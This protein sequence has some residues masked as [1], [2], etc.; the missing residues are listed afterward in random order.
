MRNLHFKQEMLATNHDQTNGKKDSACA[1]SPRLRNKTQAHPFLRDDKDQSPRSTY[2]RFENVMGFL[3]AFRRPGAT[4]VTVG[5]CPSFAMF[6]YSCL[7]SSKF[8]RTACFSASVFHAVLLCAAE[9]SRSIHATK[10]AASSV[11][12]SGEPVTDT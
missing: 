7:A 8:A 10:Y 6:S 12:R 9:I 5:Y 4:G 3:K 11:L 1:Y 2:N